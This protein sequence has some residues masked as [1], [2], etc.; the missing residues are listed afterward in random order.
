MCLFNKCP[1]G[2]EQTTLSRPPAEPR[3]PRFS[4]RAGVSLLS[5]AAGEAEPM[6]HLI[7]SSC[8]V[9]TVEMRFEAPAG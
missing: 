1:L 9:L 7:R 2:L 4:Q 3:S 8:C 6:L 5:S